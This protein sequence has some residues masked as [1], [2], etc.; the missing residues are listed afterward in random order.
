MS[1]ITALLQ[2]LLTLLPFRRKPDAEPDTAEP[3]TAEPAQDDATPAPAASTAAPAPDA[4]TE[5]LAPEGTDADMEAAIER[6]RKR[7]V[8]KKLIIIGVPALLLV[9]VI[10]SVAVLFLGSSDEAAQQHETGESATPAATTDHPATP[11]AAPSPIDP[12]EHAKALEEE[13]KKMEQERNALL[14]EKN[15]LAERNRKLQEAAARRAA[16][17]TTQPRSRS[18][19]PATT[20]PDGTPSSGEASADDPPRLSVDCTISGDL[21]TAGELLKRCIEEFNAASE[22]R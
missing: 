14:V 19:L 1:K 8:W 12:Q 15:A 10:A 2:R 18:P 5:D 20:N 22:G 3:D 11:V 7:L 4:A 6:A 21:E 9:I 13:L 17:A 16:K